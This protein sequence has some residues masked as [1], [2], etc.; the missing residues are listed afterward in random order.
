MIGKQ[1]VQV[2]GDEFAALRAGHS[3]LLVDIG[4]GDGK[5]AYHLARQRPDLLVIGIDAN[6]DNL[7][8]VSARAAAKP[9]RGG[10][11]NALFLWESAERLPDG[12]RD[13][14]ELHILMPWGSLLRGL[15]DDSDLL[16]GIAGVCRDGAEFLITLNLH[17]W[18]PPVPEVGDTTEPTPASALDGLAARYLASG[19]RLADAHYLD[20]DEIAAL[21]TSWTRRLG[22][23]RAALAVLGLTG[24]IDRGLVE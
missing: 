15:L 10:V 19:W 2:A 21:A 9:A 14:D 3:G 22:S 7:R 13:A 11:P 23:S 1:V 18:R 5:H 24:R 6:R 12:L 8:Q 17:A 16:R 4:T 20:A